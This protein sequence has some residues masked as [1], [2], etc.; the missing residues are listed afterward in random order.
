MEVLLVLIIL[1]VLAS[2]AVFAYQ[3]TQRRA[4]INAA[5]AQVGLLK[6]PLQAFQ[7][8]TGN[9]PTTA[10]GLQAL[11]YLP[12]DLPDPSKWD[13]PYLESDVPLDPWGNPYQY[14]SPGIHNPDGYDL[15]SYG[16]DRLSGTDDDIGNWN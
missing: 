6:T 3:N 4:N 16:P 2:L 1:A 14:V 11:R 7:L 12:S 8:S 15:W 9:Y 5:K 13:G 10:Q